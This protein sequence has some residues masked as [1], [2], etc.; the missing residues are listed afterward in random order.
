MDLPRKR[1]RS[2]RDSFVELRTLALILLVAL[3][4]FLLPVIIRAIDLNGDNLD[5]AWEAEHGITTG[6]YAATNL[7]GWWQL[8]GPSQV[9][10]RSANHLNGTMSDFSTNA[11]RPGL[12]SNALYF[13]PQAHADFPANAALNAAKGLTFSAW[14]KAPVGATNE[15]VIATWLDSNTNGWSVGIAANGMAKISFGNSAGKIQAIGPSINSVSLYD[16]AWHHLAATWAAGEPARV[17]VDG[18]NQGSE[19]VADWHP[20]AAAAFSFGAP[21]DS[22]TNRAFAL[23]E[24]RLYNRA[25]GPSEVVQLPATYTDLNGNGLTVWE[26]Y[27]RSLDPRATYTQ[28]PLVST[29]A[30]PV[31]ATEPGLS[32]FTPWMTD[33]ELHT[34]MSQFDS[35]PP[36]HHPNYWDKG[37]WINAVEG[38]YHD[39]AIQFRITYGP[40][41]KHKALWW[42]W[43]LGI[44]KDHFDSL[45][46]EKAAAG[47]T[48]LDANSFPMPDGSRRYQGVWH[49]V[50]FAN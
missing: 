28:K 42:Y 47:F 8:N 30:L 24:A 9:T 21:N 37:H 39:G 26:D 40:V 22:V 23:D 45:A 27:Q 13:T 3:G 43:Y 12:F 29:N 41:P 4:V 36:G 11:F 7:V 49:K 25:L 35:N 20:G 44:G 17:Y 16:G 38:R 1:V 14:V 2:P 50:I 32:D 5:D 31:T 10:D 15:T 18:E 33:P 34:F 46:A 48:L 6:A 19:I